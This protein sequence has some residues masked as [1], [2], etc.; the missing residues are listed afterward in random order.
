MQL[1]ELWIQSLEKILIKVRDIR[2]TSSADFT[3]PA[4]RK[5]RNW[6]E[7]YEKLWLG[8]NSKKDFVITKSDELFTEDLKEPLILERKC[9]YIPYDATEGITSTALAVADELKFDIP[10]LQNGAKPRP[11]NKKLNKPCL[12]ITI[13]FIPN[14]EDFRNTTIVIPHWE[15][16]GFLRLCLNSINLVFRETQMPK[17]LVIDDCSRDSTWAQVRDLV[18]EFSFEAV[19]IKR[20]DQKKVADVGKL[21]DEAIRL[22]ETE[23]ICMLD[24]DTQILTRDFLA[25][26][27]SMLQ[28]KTVISV[29]LDTNLAE[30]YHS[31]QSW[32]KYGQVDTKKVNLPGYN[33]ITNNLYRVMRTLDASAISVADP[34]SRRVQSRTYRDQLGRLIRKF[35][36]LLPAQFPKKGFSREFIKWKVINSSWP[37]MPPTSD[38]GVNANYWM[39]KNNMG[40]KI[41]VPITSYG[42][43][44]PNDGVCFQNISNYLVH[45]AL[46]TRALSNERREI[47]NAG[48]QFY[49]AVG[50]IVE[51]EYE[52]ADMSRKVREISL[53]HEFK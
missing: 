45:I 37:S 39:D 21:L 25:Y 18:S 44:T 12:A 36:S 33:A 7:G 23:Y 50:E 17:V 52:F 1:R 43:S 26:P 19:Q 16:I 32:L 48:K 46:S 15:S 2:W 47:D 34:F 41:N 51:N 8:M 24:A 22:V 20:T 53:L 31:N 40:Y 49:D 28:S 27:I 10:L 30:S 3:L 11:L 9:L 6:Q 38:N 4:W 35:D 13:D 14:F 42:L 5:A 29:G